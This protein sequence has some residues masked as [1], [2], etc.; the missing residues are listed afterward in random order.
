MLQVEKIV[1]SYRNK[2]R[3]KSTET[4]S[5]IHITQCMIEMNK[6]Y[7]NFTWANPCSAQVTRMGN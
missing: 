1:L 3:I 5:S 4:D 7:T 2:H 6:E